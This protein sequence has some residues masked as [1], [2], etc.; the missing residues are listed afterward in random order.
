MGFVA[1]GHVRSLVEGS[2]NLPDRLHKN[3]YTLQLITDPINFM[4]TN[5]ALLFRQAALA[6]LGVLFGYL[7]WVQILPIPEALTKFLVQSATSVLK[8]TTEAFSLTLSYDAMLA[9]VS[10]ASA[11]PNTVFVA[12]LAGLTI[13]YFGYQR[14]LMYSVLVWPIFLHAFHWL[15]VWHMERIATQAGI[16]PALASYQENYFFPS[17][18]LTILLIYSLFFV[19]AYFIS[20]IAR[21]GTYNQYNQGQATVSVNRNPPS[22][23][24]PPST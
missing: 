12:V 18:A 11:I 24:T 19:L 8:E 6:A 20:R 4:R 17:K 15:Y 13:R 9:L 5:T 2:N 14:L 3:S 10:F 22:N 7:L 1:Y 21:S 23:T 16:N